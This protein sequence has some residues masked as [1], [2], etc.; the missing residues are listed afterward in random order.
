MTM[1]FSVGVWVCVFVYMIMF[2]YCKNMWRSVN[3]HKMC[4]VRVQSYSMH[5]LV[6]ST[7]LGHAVVLYLLALALLPAFGFCSYSVHTGCNVV[8]TRVH[9]PQIMSSVICGCGVAMLLHTHTYILQTNI[10]A[11]Q[12][13]Y[14]YNTT[15][16]GECAI[17]PSWSRVS[18]GGRQSA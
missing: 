17:C 1:L 6:S 9:V 11:L 8:A 12:C 5:A 16:N 2:Y 14:N 18:D 3:S 7:T 4:D 15:T 13:H 10:K